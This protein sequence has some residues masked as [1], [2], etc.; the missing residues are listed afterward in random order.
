MLIIFT[1]L[2]YRR[3]YSTMSQRDKMQIAENEE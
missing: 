3:V 1:L 2:M